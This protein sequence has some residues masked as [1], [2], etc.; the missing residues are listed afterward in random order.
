MAGDGKLTHQESPAVAT[1]VRDYVS[2]FSSLKDSALPWASPMVS[3]CKVLI[4]HPLKDSQS[5]RCVDDV[6]YILSLSDRVWV[7]IS[8]SGGL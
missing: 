8:R 3:Q 4:T 7:L 2:L 1:V 5:L 6:S